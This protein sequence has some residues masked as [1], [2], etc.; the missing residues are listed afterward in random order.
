FKSYFAWAS[1]QNVIPS[2][3]EFVRLNVDFVARST[4]KSNELLALEGSWIK[5]FELASNI[6]RTKESTLR[7]PKII[8]DKADWSCVIEKRH[9]IQISESRR[10][11]TYTMY[12]NENEYVGNELLED[13]KKPELDTNNPVD[14]KTTRLT[15]RL[16]DVAKESPPKRVAK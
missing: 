1:D 6:L 3:S 11:K 13:Q 8:K 10:E 12:S 9:R 7:L 4:P 14:A 16:L 5:R 15:K 2:L